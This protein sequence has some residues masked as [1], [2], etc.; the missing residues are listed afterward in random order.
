MGVY[1]KVLKPLL[2]YTPGKV[3]SRNGSIEE[4]KVQ[5]STGKLEARS[6]AEC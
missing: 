6:S 3:K 4:M 5:R 1:L 2:L